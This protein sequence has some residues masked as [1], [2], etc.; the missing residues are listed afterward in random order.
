MPFI[1]EKDYNDIKFGCEHGV[2]LIALSFVRRAEDVLEVR[3]LLE[4]F[5]KPK[6]EI[7]SKTTPYT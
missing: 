3:K 7:I 2:D 1:S 6:M 4:E 5:G